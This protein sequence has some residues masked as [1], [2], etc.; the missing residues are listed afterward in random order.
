MHPVCPGNTKAESVIR[1]A[2]MFEAV[3][4]AVKAA[5]HDPPHEACEATMAELYTIAHDAVAIEADLVP[6]GSNAFRFYELTKMLSCQVLRVGLHCKQRL[7]HTLD[8]VRRRR[9]KTFTIPIVRLTTSCKVC[10]AKSSGRGH[11]P[12]ISEQPKLSQTPD[13]RETRPMAQQHG[14]NTKT[15][16]SIQR[17]SAT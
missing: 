5:P 13:Q 14:D 16:C 8:T 1:P 9:Q 10:S 15:L 17:S 12:R 4:A 6:A 3:V 11:C 7:V 2:E